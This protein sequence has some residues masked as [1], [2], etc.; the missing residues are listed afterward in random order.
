[1]HAFKKGTTHAL[2]STVIK[3]GQSRLVLVL[4]DQETEGYS[5]ENPLLREPLFPEYKFIP[6]EKM[7]V[8]NQTRGAHNYTWTLNVRNELQASIDFMVLACP[9]MATLSHKICILDWLYT[10][11]SE[12]VIGKTRI[13]R[14]IHPFLNWSN[15]FQKETLVDSLDTVPQKRAHPTSLNL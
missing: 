3:S 15:C 13:A 4:N 6:F 2:F 12:R 5:R 11:G 7:Q 8:V 9:A 14:K 10:G 1:M